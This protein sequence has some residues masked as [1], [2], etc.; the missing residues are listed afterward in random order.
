MLLS[1][2]F[3]I[4]DCLGWRLDVLSRKEIASIVD[5]GEPCVRGWERN[6]NFPD[7]AFE[8]ITDHFKSNGQ[9]KLVEE[10]ILVGNEPF[11]AGS[12]VSDW[13]MLCLAWLQ[14]EDHFIVK[15][16]EALYRLTGQQLDIFRSIVKLT[17]ES[18]FEAFKDA[19]QG[20]FFPMFCLPDELTEKIKA[21]T[22]WND[23]KPVITWYA[24]ESLIY[25]M[26]MAEAE[27]LKEYYNIRDSK[28]CE[29]FLSENKGGKKIPPMKAF[30][31]MFFD[32]LV[33]RN[34]FYSLDDIA[35]RLTVVGR[36]DR[37]N[38]VHVTNIDKNSAWREIKRAKYEGRAPTFE[39]FRAWIDALF[40]KGE[41]DTI[42]AIVL[43]KQ[44]I[45]DVFGAARILD[46]VY[47]DAVRELPEREVFEQFQHYP[48]WYEFHLQSTAPVGNS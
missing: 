18:R 24:I 11:R 5:R 44:L 26:S 36:S 2:K 38:V 45:I 4:N 35:E 34:H 46:A 29:W 47:K 27:Y 31:D 25:F 43:E 20:S 48:Q 15:T 13:H 7:E 10:I 19:L 41:E 12:A 3:I 42:N 9:E 23:L 28:I 32:R 22:K 17:E 6:K 33:S 16:V 40:P 1:P 30:F 8:K 21:S 39:T 37:N 14:N